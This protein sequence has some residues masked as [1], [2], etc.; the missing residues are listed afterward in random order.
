VAIREAVETD[1]EVPAVDS[2]TLGDGHDLPRKTEKPWGYELLWAWCG[3]YAAKVLHIE[4][5]HRLSLQYHRMKEET[6]FLMQGRLAIELEG[7]DGSMEEFTALPG[8]VF[9]IPAGRR[10]RMAAVETCD[11]MEVS[12]PELDDLVRLQDDFG[13]A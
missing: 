4:A 9:H 11:V 5:G 3:R 8:Q 7:S 10:H 12:T 2:L 1:L 13:R 6:L